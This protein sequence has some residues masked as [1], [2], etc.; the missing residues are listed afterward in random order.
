M[1]WKDEDC[2]N[3]HGN[4]WLAIEGVALLAVAG[5][6][7]SNDGAAKTGA[8]SQKPTRDVDQ[9]VDAVM[10]DFKNE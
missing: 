9:Q 4:Y 6:D 2:M 8:N 1:A 7:A 3:L 10:K 5:C